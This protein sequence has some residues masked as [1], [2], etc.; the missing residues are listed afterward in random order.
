M[1]YLRTLSVANIV[2]LRCQM[3]EQRREDTESKADGPEEEI[4]LVPLVHHRFHNNICRLGTTQ[5]SSN[6]WILT[7]VYI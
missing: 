5:A 7:I 1:L 2:Y 4:V 3:N 6:K